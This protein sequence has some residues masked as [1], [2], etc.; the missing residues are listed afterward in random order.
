M[1]KLV[2]RDESAG[3]GLLLVKTPQQYVAVASVVPESP[4]A[5]EGIRLGQFL[6]TIDGLATKDLTLLEAQHML[7]GPPGST[8]K[9]GYFRQSPDAEEGAQV[10]LT[11]ADLSA[12]SVVVETPAEGVA[13]VRVTDLGEGAAKRVAGALSQVK[14]SGVS[15]LVLD[16]RANVGGSVREALALAELFVGP[17]PVFGEKARGALRVLETEAPASWDGDLV[18][19]VSR[20][21]VGEAELVA[22]ALADAEAGPLVGKPTFGKR[23]RQDTVRFRDGSGLHLTVAEYVDAEGEALDEDGVQPNEDVAGPLLPEH[24]GEHAGVEPDEEPPAGG[25]GEAMPADGSSEATPEQDGAG[26]ADPQLERAL[27]ILA[28]EPVRKAA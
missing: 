22:R 27:E 18:V 4:A 19:L 15:E 17:R 14:A 21:T 10:E 6:E 16:L 3:V 8:V 24:P 26:S 25:S 20:G 23:T 11:R 1:A 13:L 5:V 2:D 12:L 28:G 9:L 7:R